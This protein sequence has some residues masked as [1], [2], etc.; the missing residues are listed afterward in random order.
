MFAVELDLVN[1]LSSAMASDFAQGCVFFCIFNMVP[2]KTS[3]FLCLG[4]GFLLTK[5]AIF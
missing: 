1:S 5:E 4:K 2:F 3:V